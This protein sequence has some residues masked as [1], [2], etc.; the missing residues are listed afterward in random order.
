MSNDTPREWRDATRAIHAGEAL[1]GVNG[2][3]ATTIVRSSTFTF[4]STAEMKRWAEG[5]SKAYIYTRYGNPTLTVAE[6]KIAEL[7]RAEAASGCSFWNGGDFVRDHGGCRSGRRNYRDATIVWRLLPIDARCAAA[8]RNKSKSRGNGS[9]RRGC[10]RHSANK[11][12]LCGDAHESYFAC[13]GFAQSRGDCEAAQARR[14]GRQH[15]R[16]AGSAKTNRHGIRLGDAQ[17]DEI[18]RRAFGFDRRRRC[19]QQEVDRQSSHDDYLSRRVDGSRR[20]V[21]PDSRNEI[22]GAACDAAM[23]KRDEGREISGETPESCARALSRF[24]VASGSQTLQETNA[25]W[26]WWNARVRYERRTRGGAASVRPRANIFDGGKSRRRRVAGCVAALHFA[27][28]NERDGISAS[29]SR[30]R[31]SANV[32]RIGRSARFDRRSE[33]SAEIILRACVSRAA[34]S[35][36]IC[37]AVGFTCATALAEL[38]DLPLRPS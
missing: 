14:D 28:Q 26:I 21:S 11:S 34:G 7:E 27:L 36:I 9:R 38:I 31:N 30:A 17:R 19:R 8:I 18:P 1:H 16:I 4:A 23:R 25:E 13:G 35:V 2:P 32:N 29:R 37:I 3:V 24:E 5:K 6:A 10:A 22:A 12:N 15:V 20:R 33:A